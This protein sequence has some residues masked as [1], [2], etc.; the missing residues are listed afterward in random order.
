MIFKV[1][2][3]YG[4]YDEFLK[5]GWVP[6]TIGSPMGK[7]QVWIISGRTMAASV[8]ENEGYLEFDGNFHEND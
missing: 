2:K 3:S 5:Y 6:Q 1:K 7:N 8:P 4:S